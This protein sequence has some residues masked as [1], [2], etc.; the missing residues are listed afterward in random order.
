M[1]KAIIS[2]KFGERTVLVSDPWDYIEMWLKRNSQKIDSVFYWQQARHFYEA[3]KSLQSTSSPLTLY[4]CFLNAVKVL[5]LE[6]KVTFSNHHGVH[7][8]SINHKAHL[9][10]PESSLALAPT[11]VSISQCPKCLRV[12]TSFGRSS[13][14][15]TSTWRFSRSFDQ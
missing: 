5:L 4:Y 10:K 8:K 2:P 13:M 3:S 14:E 9:S 1:H 15:A 6:K 7:G 11:K 12:S